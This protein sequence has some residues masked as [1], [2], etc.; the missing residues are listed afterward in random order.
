MNVE[1]FAGH[2]PGPWMVCTDATE[3]RSPELMIWTSKGPGFGTVAE[4][5]PH[6]SPADARLIAAA[7]DLLAENVRLRKMIAEYAKLSDEIYEH[8]K[9]GR[10]W[11]TNVSASDTIQKLSLLNFNLKFGR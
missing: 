8:H 6:G 9:N 7:P 10:L 2:T 5:S 1:D 3:Y 11:E 4:V